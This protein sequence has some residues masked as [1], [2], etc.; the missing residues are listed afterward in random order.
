MCVVG[1][2]PLCSVRLLVPPLRLMSAFMWRVVQQQNLEYFDKLEEYI[3]LITRM[4]PEI[5]SERQKNVLIMGLRAK[6]RFMGC[7]PKLLILLL[8]SVTGKSRKEETGSFFNKDTQVVP[9]HKYFIVVA[10][11][12]RL[13]YKFSTSPKTLTTIN[14][15][16]I[17]TT[18][19]NDPN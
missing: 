4:V 19:R 13:G 11:G 10:L 17:I 5:L 16:I 3:L 2:L 14:D 15:T 18:N 8:Q 1:S 6:V 12:I 7:F 9:K